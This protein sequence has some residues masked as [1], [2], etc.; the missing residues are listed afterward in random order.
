[1]I[2]IE[3]LRE[4]GRLLCRCPG[5]LR[6]DPTCPQQCSRC[7]RRIHRGRDGDIQDWRAARFRFSIRRVGA[8][9]QVGR[10]PKAEVT[11]A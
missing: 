7:F 8:I 10:K 3:E 11:S 1:V 6:R 2:P 5:L 4:M 9:P